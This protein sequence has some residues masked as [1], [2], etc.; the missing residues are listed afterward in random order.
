MKCLVICANKNG[1]NTD[2][3]LIKYNLWFKPFEAYENES[4][5][6]ENPYFCSPKFLME[7]LIG[8]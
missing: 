8:Y 7:E 4:L 3:W 5:I 6:H 1:L 2:L